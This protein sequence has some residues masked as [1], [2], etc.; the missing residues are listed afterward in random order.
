[1]APSTN[2][3]TMSPN[4]R[5]KPG[6]NKTTGEHLQTFWTRYEHLKMN[7]VMKNVLFEV[8]RRITQQL[9]EEVT[10]Y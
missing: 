9:S 6:A 7:D 5:A 4:G 8:R 10:E 1:M 2:G 3:T